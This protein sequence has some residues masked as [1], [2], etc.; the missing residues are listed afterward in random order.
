MRGKLIDKEG[1][2]KWID[3]PKGEPRV[4]KLP[5][6]IIPPLKWYEENEL[7]PLTPIGEIPK[8][9]VFGEKFFE[10]VTTLVQSGA[11]KFMVYH[12]RG[13]NV[14]SKTTT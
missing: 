10:Y 3:L 1:N 8:D 12:E 13:N 14:T 5:Y 7:M 9:Y 4:L 2:V 6:M 11:K